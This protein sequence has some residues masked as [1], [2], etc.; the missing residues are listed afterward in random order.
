[1]NLKHF[2]DYCAALQAA[3]H[4]TEDHAEALAAFFDKRPGRYQG[5]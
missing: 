2:L 5:R 4:G 1:M 3:C